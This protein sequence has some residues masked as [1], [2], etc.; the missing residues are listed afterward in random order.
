MSYPANRPSENDHVESDSAHY[1]TAG[2]GLILVG[3]IN[4]LVAL[5]SIV[6]GTENT[7]IEYEMMLSFGITF[8][9]IGSWMKSLRS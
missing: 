2:M 3:M 5:Y 8:V 1:N 6:Q 9:M 4:S 7:F